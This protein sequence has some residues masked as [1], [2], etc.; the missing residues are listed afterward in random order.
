MLITW[1]CV[2]KLVRSLNHTYDN[3]EYTPVSRCSIEQIHCLFSYL[4]LEKQDWRWPWE[5]QGLRGS[6]ESETD[7][8]VAQRTGVQW[9]C[10]FVAHL[11]PVTPSLQVCSLPTAH[12][13]ITHPRLFD[14]WT[15]W[16][17]EKG[18][19]V[20]I[21]SLECNVDWSYSIAVRWLRSLKSAKELLTIVWNL[22][23]Q[24]LLIVTYL[25]C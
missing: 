21:F 12:R 4:S 13:S 9:K 10:A 14:R 23:S 5:S 18:M 19:D 24:I 7:A 22:L 11:R 17:P 16:Q 20:R 6:E 1:L 3:N 15:V 8:A 25:N 2:V